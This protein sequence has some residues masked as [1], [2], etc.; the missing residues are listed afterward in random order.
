MP[1]LF[2]F[3]S[4]K[5]PLQA[6]K[7]TY[8]KAFLNNIES[9][10]SHITHPLL[11]MSEYHNA[12]QGYFSQRLVILEDE[13]EHHALI[14]TFKAQYAEQAIALTE[15]LNILSEMAEKQP[16]NSEIALSGYQKT[17]DAELADINKSV[18]EFFQNVNKDISKLLGLLFRALFKQSDSF[19]HITDQIKEAIRN[20]LPNIQRKTLAIE[21]HLFTTLRALLDSEG[22]P[23]VVRAQLE[24]TFETLNS[25]KNAKFMLVSLNAAFNTVPNRLSEIGCNEQASITARIQDLKG[26]LEKKTVEPFLHYLMTAQDYFNLLLR[27]D[28][29]DASLVNYIEE[30]VAEGDLLDRLF[31]KFKSNELVALIKLKQIHRTALD[32]E[33][34]TLEEINHEVGGSEPLNNL[35]DEYR[36]RIRAMERHFAMDTLSDY[37]KLNSFSEISN[38]YLTVSEMIELHSAAVRKKAAEY[39]LVELIFKKANCLAKNEIDFFFKEINDPGCRK[40]SVKSL[41]DKIFH[42]LGKMPASQFGDYIENLLKFAETEETPLPSADQSDALSLFKKTFRESIKGKHLACFI[43]Q[44]S[45]KIAEYLYS[46]R[47]D[48]YDCGPFSRLNS[49]LKYCDLRQLKALGKSR[50]DLQEIIKRMMS[51]KQLLDFQNKYHHGSLWDVCVWF[52]E[53][54]RDE[55]SLPLFTAT[56]DKNWFFDTMNIL[57]MFQHAMARI[58]YINKESSSKTTFFFLNTGMKAKKREALEQL[59]EQLKTLPHRIDDKMLDEKIKNWEA[60]FGS[61]IDKQRYRFYLIVLVMVYQ[62]FKYI[63]GQTLETKSR[64]CVEHLKDRLYKVNTAMQASFQKAITDTSPLARGLTP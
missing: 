16:V 9:F 15:R 43:Q 38:Y 14:R 47:G 53:V 37:F 50:S 12:L 42:L 58:D 10:K 40:K 22:L 13:I 55:L 48:R 34:K 11:D 64:H 3:R 17:L 20:D 27:L 5:R 44:Q 30:H 33:L 29:D 25:S 2:D 51:T 8:K 26:F 21:E 36:V 23:E 45:E 31:R 32:R 63:L 19:F 60:E 28:K 59:K 6:R 18:Q 61:V 52:S 4:K 57:D 62:V 46:K 56:Q 24:S 1:N 41:T 7:E 39:R 35:I 49:Y 54:N